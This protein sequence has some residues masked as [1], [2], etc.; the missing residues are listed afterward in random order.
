VLEQIKKLEKD[1]QYSLLQ[2]I[3]NYGQKSFMILA[4]GGSIGTGNV[5]KL[6][7]F[8]KS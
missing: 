1:Q 7:F 8:E 4:P 5:L 2:R 6:F 3:V